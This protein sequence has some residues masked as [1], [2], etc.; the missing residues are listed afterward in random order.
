MPF[1]HHNITLYCRSSGQTVTI[2]RPAT[3]PRQVVT[4]VTQVTQI[5]SLDQE[6]YHWHCCG[7]LPHRPPAVSSATSH[8]G[9]QI[10]VFCLLMSIDQNF[11]SR[12]NVPSVRHKN[13]QK[14]NSVF[15]K[16]NGKGLSKATGA[17]NEQRRSHIFLLC[18]EQSPPKLPVTSLP[19]P[20][21][22]RWLVP[23]P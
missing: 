21:G 6:L 7:R 8:P 20:L 4:Q 18:A 19:K 11:D 17:P 15:T 12:C 14:N 13:P 22:E 2:P 3:R 5:K 1:R 10:C 9:K 16:E 23:K